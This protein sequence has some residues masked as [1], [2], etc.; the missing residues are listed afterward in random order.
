MAAVAAAAL[1]AGLVV[2]AVMACYSVIIRHELPTRHVVSL[3]F[4]YACDHDVHHV[5]H[6]CYLRSGQLVNG[7]LMSVL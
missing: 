2:V 4:L 3:R 5:M 7:K 6:G 1:V